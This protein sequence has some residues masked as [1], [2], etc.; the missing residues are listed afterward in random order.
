MFAVRPINSRMTASS[1]RHGK[2]THIPD[3][4]QL[5]PGLRLP[6]H[7][8]RSALSSAWPK[9]RDD[10]AHVHP[11]WG[12]A[13]ATA[14]YSVSLHPFSPGILFTPT[15]SSRSGLAIGLARHG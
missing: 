3:L 8:S 7:A 11:L 14:V 1:V 13:T 9:I 12:V 15:L 10:S 4:F 6:N 2:G 5:A